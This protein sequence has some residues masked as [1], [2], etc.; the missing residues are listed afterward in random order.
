MS[1]CDNLVRGS[2]EF[3][4]C[5]ISEIVAEVDKLS[6]GNN[7]VP[8]GVIGKSHA[9]LELFFGDYTVF[10]LIV[11]ACIMLPLFIWWILWLLRFSR[12]KRIK[13]GGVEMELEQAAEKIS[14]FMKDVQAQ[15]VRLTIAAS[16]AE[17]RSGNG[18]DKTSEF[19][20]PEVG[21]L[22]FKSMLD[23]PVSAK[24]V[25]EDAPVREFNPKV[26]Y[27]QSL[28]KINILWLAKDKDQHDFEMAVTKLLGNEVDYVSSVS[29]ALKRLTFDG[30]RYQ[31]IVAEP[32]WVG[33]THGGW[34][35][36]NRLAVGG[37]KT[38]EG[39]LKISEKLRFAIFAESEA[40]VRQHWDKINEN[41]NAIITCKIEYLLNR[42]RWLQS[43]ASAAT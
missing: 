25:N 23:M 38:P 3:N 6:D 9:Q 32:G 43:E 15:V 19:A 11:G 7:N 12:L 5:S 17:I 26:E 27:K 33:F 41:S 20:D 1:V 29:K 18:K 35:L 34:D 37:L 16:E 42:I 24:Q 8:S 28:K 22:Q 36:Y 14:V 2:V 31:L 40:I 4:T 30:G 39:T 10:A 13:L 21:Q